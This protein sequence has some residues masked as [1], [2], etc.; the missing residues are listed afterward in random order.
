MKKKIPKKKVRPVAVQV[1]DTV[2]TT[3]PDTSEQLAVLLD[4]VKDVGLLSDKVEQDV[5]QTIFTGF[6]RASRVAGAPLGCMVLVHGPSRGGKTAFAGGLV[7][8]FQR[9]GHL[10]YYVDSETTLSKKWYEQCEIA[11]HLLPYDRPDSYEEAA[12]KID[13]VITNFKNG[14][15]KG[16]IDESQGLLIVIDSITKLT[17]KKELEKAAS[18]EV[19]KTFPL[20]ALFNSIWL[21][22]LTP[23]VAKLPILFLMI[24]HEKR[25]METDPK[26]AKFK[27][28]KPKGGDALIYDTSMIVHVDTAKKLNVTRTKGGKKITTMIGQQHRAKVTK[29][30]LGI[31]SEEFYFVMSNGKGSTPIGFDLAK[32][33]MH[34][35]RVRDGIVCPLVYR[36]PYWKCE[37][38]PDGKIKGENKT[39][40]FLRR[41]PKVLRDIVDQLNET[42]IEAVVRVVD[43]E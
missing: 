1:G 18:G 12:N 38:F 26:M 14:R 22:K 43:D 23:V 5:V 24:A 11:T 29:N 28:F 9:S 42:A 20:R 37:A 31:V 30:K 6:N 4:G 36:S 34:E 21:D 10:A 41:N 2:M 35:V 40:A 27:R 13:K 25:V 15:E 19:G 32:D 17:P 33:V 3:M 8:S 7:L 39:A 16:T